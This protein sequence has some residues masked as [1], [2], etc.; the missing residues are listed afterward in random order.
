MLEKTSC[1]VLFVNTAK[2]F[3]CSRTLT[4]SKVT[5][6]EAA[7]CIQLNNQQATFVV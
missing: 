2:D 5:K 3:V 6:N 4:Y 1:G 7:S